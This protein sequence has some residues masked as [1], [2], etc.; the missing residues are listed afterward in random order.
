MIY[1]IVFKQT[2]LLLKTL[3]SSLLKLGLRLMPL[4]LVGGRLIPA[5]NTATTQS[6]QKTLFFRME[7]ASLSPSST[8]I[9]AG[10]YCMQVV[11]PLVRADL[12]V[13]LDDSTGK[14]LVQKVMPN[15]F[16]ST[17]VCAP[18]AQ[19]RYKLYILE[20]PTWAATLNVEAQ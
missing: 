9:T 19:G 17:L 1:Q 8:T 20:N 7:H 4:V 18:L 12:T 14:M 16:T 5:Q 3:P 2:M 10:P 11:N 13:R 6:G 15:K